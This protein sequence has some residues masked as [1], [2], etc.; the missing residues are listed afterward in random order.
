MGYPGKC[1]KRFA[2]PAHPW[3]AERIAEEGKVVR[4]YGLRNK[5]EIRKAESAIRKYRR[6]TRKL[7]AESYESVATEVNEHTKHEKENILNSLK[8]K[9]ILG[10]DAQL[11]DILSLS[12]GSILDRRLQT[13][14]CRQGLARTMK[15][16]R[17]FVVH[18]HITVANR[19]ITI[20][21]YIV[22]RVEESQIEYN[23]G[24]PLLNE[25]HPAKP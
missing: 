7:L 17:Q 6:G 20:P 4:T 2:T 13:Q 14:V 10:A 16:A 21:S 22:N 1:K 12:I 8:V 5:R 19:K 18:G 23:V 11:D 25:T 15:Q 9:G 24:S 3:Q